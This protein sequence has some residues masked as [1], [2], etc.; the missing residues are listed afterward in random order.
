MKKLLVLMMA[1]VMTL[2]LAGC[3]GDE[4]EGSVS[5]VDVTANGLTIKLPNDIKYVITNETNGAMIY[6]NDESTAIITISAMAVDPVTS[7]DI[8]DDVLLVALTAGGG[9][10]DG[11]LEKSRTIEH[12]DG[13]KSVVGFG[14]GALSNETDM[15]SVI[16]YYFPADGSGY[17]VIS[18]LYVVDAGSSMENTIEQVISSIKTA[19]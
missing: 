9:L 10:S 11:A 16:H 3:G 17:H 15:N 6:A 13:G 4:K 5:L 14:K 19:N 7:S 18:Y 2:S 8:T 1:L 12:E